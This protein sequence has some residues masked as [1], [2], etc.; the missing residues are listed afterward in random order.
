MSDSTPPLDKGLHT[1]LIKA[2]LPAWLAH[3]A[4]ADINRLR[5]GLLPGRIPP[6]P[7]PAWLST[8]TPELRKA[9]S[10]SQARS[11]TANQVL[12]KTLSLL[13]G[14]TEFAQ[15]LLVEALSKRFGQ[16]LDVNQNA[17]FYLRYREV[18]EQH[19]LLQAALLNF[20][21]NED[22]TQQALGET[23]ALAP[24]GALK[25]EYGEFTS[26][27]SWSARYRYTQ[28]LS[29]TPQDF[30]TL[31]RTLDLGQ[32]Y[33]A[34]LKQVFD[35]PERS[36]TVREQMISAQ[37]ALMAVRTH[38]ARMKGEIA[39]PA[40]NLL[41]AIQAGEDRPS[42]AG[43]AVVY[44]Q[45]SVLGFTLAEVV[46][47]GAPAV[48]PSGTIF[49]W[50]SPTAPGVNLLT[51]GSSTPRGRF[52]VWIP[53][54]P[55]APIKDYATLEAFDKDLAINLRSP[56]YQ[57]LFCSLLPQG[58]AAAFLKRLQEKLFTYK[59]N[60]SKGLY[61]QQYDENISLNLRE[62]AL[63]GELFGA[64]YDK[65][66]Q[67]L[68]ENALKLAVP[69]AEADRKAAQ[70]RR[71]HWLSLGLNV[72]NVAAFIVPG[73][74]EVMLAV[75]A[76]QLGMEVYHGI[77]SW[78][79]GDL[80]AAWAHLES[81]A[82]NLAFMATL[83]GAGALASRAPVIQVSKWVDGLVPVKLPG[84]EARLWKPD[85]APYRSEVQLDPSIKPNAQGQYETGG[86]IYIR[87]GEGVYEKGFDTQLKKW[88]IK[89]PN[90]PAAYQP[91]LQG[92]NAGAW[93]GI[94]ERPREWDRLTL[95]RRLGHDTHG[96]SDEALTTL[97]DISG[98]SEETLRKVHIDGLP[99]P[100]PLAETLRQFRVDQQVDELI[101]Q[102]RSGS[103]L[104]PHYEYTLPLVVEMPRWPAGR[105]LEVFEG[106]EPWGRS[107]RYGSPLSAADVRATIKVTR[108]EVRQG[109][110]AR[111][112]LSELSEQESADMLGREANGPEADRAQL[113]NR[114]LA[115]VALNR[116]QALFDGMSH[117]TQPAAPDSEWIQR[118][119]AML[120][121]E[122][123]GEILATASD[124]ERAQMRKTGKP[125]ER[126][127]NL[128]RGYA[129]QARLSRA[130]TGL[131]RET[132]ASVDSHRLALHSLGRLPGW[133]ASVRLELRAGNITGVLLDSVGPETA[134]IRRVLVKDGDSF[135]AYNER[136]VPL[137]PVGSGTRNFSESILH[138]LPD[139]VRRG[140]GFPLVSQQADLQ[141]ALTRYATAHRSEMATVLKQRIVRART[142]WQRFGGRLGYG[143]SGRGVGVE[144]EGSLVARVQDLYPNLSEEQATRFVQARLTNGENRSQVAHIVAQRS[145]EFSSLQAALEGWMNEAVGNP[146]L[147]GPRRRQM[148][149]D[150]IACWRQNL[151]RGLPA[152]AHLDLVWEYRLPDLQADF[153]HVRSLKLQGAAMAGE[154]GA[155]LF[156]QFPNVQRLEVY[157]Q[158]ASLDAVG[159]RLRNLTNINELSIDGHGLDYPQ[160]FGRVLNAMPQLESLALSGTMEALDVSGLP[161]LRTLVVSGSLVTL[162]VGVADLAQLE[163]LNLWGTRI[164]SLPSTIFQGH[165]RVWR[166]L[167]LNWSSFTPADFMQ[168]FEHLSGNTAHL[169]D[170]ERLVQNYCRGSL[171]ALR[172]A[173]SPLFPDAVA[174]F[175]HLGLSG[176]D[177]VVRVNA[178]REEHSTLVGALDTWKTREPRVDHQLVD[179]LYRQR[180]AE[181]LLAC[182]RNG[183]DR[184][185]AGD[186]PLPIDP[187]IARL[188]LS[189]G[190][191]GEFPQLPA[192]GFGHVQHLN[193]GRARVPVQ[194]LDAL[195]ERFP[196]LHRLGLS[197]NNLATLPSTLSD[198][199]S[200]AG[201]DLS[202][203]QLTVTSEIQRQL[204]RLTG[205]RELTLSYNR[206]DRLDVG[207]LNQL[208]SL[209]LAHTG[210]KVWPTG[211]LD[212]PNLVRLDLSCSA[213]TDVPLTALSGHDPLML[214]TYVQGCRLNTASI[215]NLQ[216][217]ALRTAVQS[218]LGISLELLAQGRTGG[219]PEF[220]P[221]ES[222]ENPNLTIPL[223]VPPTGGEAQMT[224]AA[225]LQRLDPALSTVDAIRRIDELTAQ[226]AGGLA[227]RAVEARLGQWSQQHDE[228]IGQLNAWIDIRGY[229]DGGGWVQALDRRRAADRLLESWRRNLHAQ[230][231]LTATD[232]RHIVD[233]SGLSV[234][235]LPALG[236]YFGHVRVL[237]LSEVKL[238]EEG[239]NAFLRGFPGL[240]ALMLNKNGLSSLPEAVSEM[241]TL[242]R[243]EANYNDFR[244]AAE[245][246]RQLDRLPEL[247]WLDL[248]DNTLD[249]LDIS[250]LHNLETLNL[251][252]N[253]L[254]DWPEGVLQAPHLRTLN[255]SNNQI[256]A[257]PHAAL[258]PQHR[259]LMAG[260]DLS[261]N[262]LLEPEFR[263]L[264]D[265]LVETGNGLGFT[266]REID[267]LLDGYEVTDEESDGSAEEDAHPEF[268]TDREQKAQ[269][270]CGVAAD[271][272]KLVAW[273]DL[274]A[275]DGNSQ[276]FYIISRLKSTR[277]FARDRAE[278]TGR[279]WEVVETSYQD[280][281]LRRLMFDKARALVHRATCGDGWALLFN[282]LEV[283]VYEY[284]ALKNVAPGQEGASLFRLARGMI[285][286]DEVE[287]QAGEAIRQRPGVDEAEVR[288]A[289]R[290]GLAQRLMLPRQPVSMLYQ[291][292]SRVTDV[293]IN[294]AYASII[295]KESTPGFIDKLV[296]R[297][298]WV[299]YLKRKYLDEFSALAQA[300]QVRV[301]ALESRHSDINEQYK[302]EVK[303]LADQE[304]AA[305]K[306]L[307]LQLS[308]RERAELD[309]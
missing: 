155:A 160:D 234:G 91:E 262:L 202:H 190:A 165:E 246:K 7:P 17:L 298:Y 110:L 107:Q 39:E 285:R 62:T 34:H 197:G 56:A 267:R 177:R 115:D 154:D 252:G 243:L 129:Q 54:A 289:Y 24:V 274:K 230:A 90:D 19:T 263:V 292:L 30:S 43:K 120:S 250:G 188:D 137:N 187:R 116:K 227:A 23:S 251:H 128:A 161:N 119:F 236:R 2:R 103:G 309:L 8:A 253:I 98:V 162:P 279:V 248:S 68:K 95:L 146:Q 174:Q 72:L 233:L 158:Q 60:A 223:P 28:K 224:S 305:Q 147:V 226:G 284:N 204:N 266:Q 104:H 150:L 232:G 164:N 35:A 80:D 140:L 283:G 73:L 185:L 294:R 149:Q 166:A 135:R 235:D 281:D 244:G 132:S 87:I 268:L 229:R 41:L 193:L 286:L 38:T 296:T 275:T 215:S 33:Q 142:P 136:G 168:V 261:D 195:L 299:N 303:A 11:R 55:L 94:H 14:P 256:E 180:A 37:K 139:D 51:L 16:T 66:V 291:G 301:E 228:L 212:L 76:I 97:G 176:R 156:R 247:T 245:L 127:D 83:A 32:Q 69:T 134:S 297:E 264:R 36:A 218:P 13:K 88:R 9:L 53:G 21:G 92:N 182:W 242:T 3:S 75:T 10:D 255:L 306:T 163:K 152:H 82:L 159:E 101:A 105:V 67:R 118:R 203:N 63:S 99:V 144:D 126:L 50:L 271:S 183:L 194:A 287:A 241:T 40:Y 269:W 169:V 93:R 280:A 293:D 61:E 130:M 184:R 189:G 106:P 175:Q 1:S 18:T 211:V 59:W 71:E 113:F 210:T 221:V 258:S 131:L 178:L 217:F 112:V 117:P 220:F 45:L 78:K 125:P 273:D 31:C 192:Q 74:G 282:E 153:S 265:H 170:E 81:V 114:R 277:D 238:T 25:T 199:H 172:P 111:Q 167:H 5:A 173:D 207:R 259:Q 42:L 100:A 181:N 200:L 6:G 49:D 209:S 12:A 15:P 4:P 79:Q 270:S 276:F 196:G 133:P 240:R 272:E 260:T 225:R 295:A 171:Q 302:T 77:E 44:S 201:L 96:L 29:I 239:S 288:L 52:V 216:R 214:S 109:K 122:A 124:Q 84:G 206:I 46:L 108:A 86:R 138:A 307:A 70:E 222:A 191:L 22:F 208:R 213:I 151:Y 308:T 157:A 254:A 300:H 102:I 205:L 143:L 141:R 26:A 257:V 290:I 219:D 89:H 231:G 237:N 121:R 58:D 47:I 198:L 65:H 64:L 249:S 148:A 179:F 85:L 145:R 278:L 27:G 123:M 48:G 20:E 304:T 57:Q 186:N